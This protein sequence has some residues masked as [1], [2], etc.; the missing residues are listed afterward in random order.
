MTWNSAW[1]ALTK[2]GEGVG[3]PTGE[4]DSFL[5]GFRMG[6]GNLG[7]RDGRSQLQQILDDWF[8]SLSQMDRK[9][10]VSLMYEGRHQGVNKSEHFHLYEKFMHLV[11]TEY[12]RLKNE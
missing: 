3:L 12:H 9:R 10:L 8:Q 4:G 11:D 6:Q 5:L 7:F 2:I 1:E